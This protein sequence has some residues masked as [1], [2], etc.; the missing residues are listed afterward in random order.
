[1]KFEDFIGPSYVSQAYSV[2]VQRTINWYTERVERPGANKNASSLVR[3]PGR[4]LYKDLGLGNGKVRGI[5]TLE[6]YLWAAKNDKFVELKPDGTF[7]VF[8]QSIVDDD[9][10]VYI[11]GNSN[12]LFVVSGGHGYRLFGGAFTEIA[13]PNF[14]VGQ[15]KG[16]FFLDGYFGTAVGGTNRFQISDLNNSSIWDPTQEGFKSAHPDF[17]HQIG[18]LNREV[19]TLGS[20]TIQVFDDVGDIDFPFSVRTDVKIDMGIFASDSVVNIGNTWYFIA[21]NV[22]GVNIAM[23]TNGYALSPISDYAFASFLDDNKGS[24]DAVGWGYEEAGHLFYMLY[25][26]SADR[27]WGYDTTSGQWHERTWLDPNTG[28]EHADRNYCAASLNNRVIVGDRMDGNLYEINKGFLDDNGQLIRR[29]RISP[30]I[31][32]ELDGIIHSNFIVDGNVGLGDPTISDPDDPMFD[33]KMMLSWSDDGGKTFGNIHQRG[34][35]RAGEFNRRPIWRRLG[36]SRRRVYKS[37]VTAPA[38]WAI[39]GVYINHDPKLIGR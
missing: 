9:L 19:W 26:P 10:P 4:K 27:T 24:S 36:R 5:F 31:S 23:K 6:G 32:S 7:T 16:A 22:L 15:A 39:A 21:G 1:M 13:D 2:D 28:M 3:T 12:E 34:F 25:F 20:Q 30:C 8:A 35:G 11:T 18:E 14:P 17:I 37:V 33:P 38:D 29:V